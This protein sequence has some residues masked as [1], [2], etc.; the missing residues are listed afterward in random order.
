MLKALKQPLF[1]GLASVYAECD[2]NTCDVSP[3]T[4]PEEAPM[5]T[6]AGADRQQAR[7]R[8]FM[9]LLP[10]TLE[11]AGLPKSE[12]GRNFNEGQLEVRIATI[13]NAFRLA[14]QLVLEVSRGNTDT[15]A[16]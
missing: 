2:G 13:R 5:S 9:S 15:E 11:L 3:L 1:A 8:E 4:H 14:K 12:L 6:D 10:L 7:M 16:R